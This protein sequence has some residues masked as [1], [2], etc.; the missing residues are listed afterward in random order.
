MTSTKHRKT[1]RADDKYDQLEHFAAQFR[2]P[3]C[4]KRAKP[5]FTCLSRL[6]TNRKAIEGLDV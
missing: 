6:Q 2:I 4:Q 5:S 1:T 3:Q